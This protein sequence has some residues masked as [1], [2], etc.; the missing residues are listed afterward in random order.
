ML[1]ALEDGRQP[2]TLV[3]AW[4]RDRA[5]GKLV[6]IGELDARRNGMASGC[7]CPACR[8]PLIAVNA[9]KAA[10]TLKR[11]PHFRH[12]AGTVKASC[13][14][15]VARMAALRSFEAGGVITLPG[16]RWGGRRFGF[17]GQAHSVWI[18]EPSERA[19]V[20]GFSMLDRTTALLRLDDGRELEVTL[21]GSMDEALAELVDGQVQQAKAAHDGSALRARIAIVV[22]DPAVAGLSPEELRSR[23][24]LMTEGL[25]WR[26]HWKD[27]DLAKRA[28]DAADAL[29]AS[30][31][32]FLPPDAVE[33]AEILSD[34]PRELWRETLLHLEV[35]HI[36]ARSL[37]LHTPSV[38]IT[39]ELAC[40]ER[41]PLRRIWSWPPRW[42]CLTDVRLERA[43]GRLVPDVT[44]TAEAETLIDGEPQAVSF[45]PL[46]IEVTVTNT[47]DDSR[48]ERIRAGG[49]AAIEIDLSRAAGQVDRATLEQLVVEDIGIKRWHFLPA[50]E[51]AKEALRAEL[52]GER[53]AILERQQGGDEARQQA[54]S[55]ASV[56]LDAAVSRSDSKAQIEE[57][58]HRRLAEIRRQTAEMEEWSP[59][60]VALAYKE[61]VGKQSYAVR[62][63]NKWAMTQFDPWG[64]ADQEMLDAELKAVVEELQRRGFANAGHHDMV[65]P[66]GI[67]VALMSIQRGFPYGYLYSSIAMMIHPLRRKRPAHEATLYLM[68]LKTWKPP[69]SDPEQATVSEWGREVWESIRNGQNRYLRPTQNDALLCALFPELASGLADE[70]LWRSV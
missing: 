36:L 58:L 70:R 18:E 24:T 14:V 44:C 57:R 63:V 38:T 65:S 11:R 53:D 34:L 37:R 52:V 29:A 42:M 48:V 4:A 9:G 12:P 46:L 35:K 50:A 20:R 43:L 40:G 15:L 61:V 23:L 55:G 66:H 1:H 32:D 16:R 5:T 69:L 64:M 10:G 51:A 30:H 59:E 39:E 21:L 25:C 41:E 13:E 17:E 31:F 3:L 67:V 60:R 49:H 8:Q 7:E 6:Y 27:R 56:D 28:G 45:S 26:R 19:R 68:A 62:P 33:R 2:E 47:I 54:R 22:D